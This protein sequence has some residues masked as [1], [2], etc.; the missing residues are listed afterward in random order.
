MTFSEQAM[1]ESFFLS[2][3]APQAPGFNRGIWKELEAVVREWAGHEEELI[4]VSGPIFSDTLGSIGANEVTVP[5]YFYK[6][7]YDLSGKQKMIGFILPNRKV[8]ASLQVFAVS[9]DEVEKA[10]EI[11]FFYQMLRNRKEKKLE[12]SYSISDWGHGFGE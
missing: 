11:D 7:I 5:G 9:V 3:M 12:R 2:N 10:T 1:S 4:V 8:E 6:V